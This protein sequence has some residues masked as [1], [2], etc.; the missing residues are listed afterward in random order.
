MHKMNNFVLQLK[1][2]VEQ[3]GGW[4]EDKKAKKV[5]DHIGSVF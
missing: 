3:Y 1:D 2:I 5:G 4:G